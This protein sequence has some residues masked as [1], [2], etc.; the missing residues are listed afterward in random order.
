MCA[1]QQKDDIILLWWAPQSVSFHIHFVTIF[2]RRAP[3]SVDARRKHALMRSPS[4]GAAPQ[5]DRGETFIFLYVAQVQYMTRP[6]RTHAGRRKSFLATQYISS[7]GE[8]DHRS[9]NGPSDTCILLRRERHPHHSRNPHP[10]VVRRAAKRQGSGCAPLRGCMACRRISVQ[11]LHSTLTI[12][13]WRVPPP[14]HTL[15]PHHSLWTCST[16]GTFTLSSSCVCG[17]FDISAASN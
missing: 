2:L 12:F 13:L 7:R 9:R 17:S 6:E 4:V 15:P 16:A 3:Q 14:G 8:P 5:E 10:P 1:H 11:S